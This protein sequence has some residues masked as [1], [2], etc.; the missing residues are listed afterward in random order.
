[1]REL[2]QGVCMHYN[3]SSLFG[4]PNLNYSRHVESILSLLYNIV[5]HNDYV[6]NSRK[7]ISCDPF[8]QNVKDK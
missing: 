7:F 8:W 4:N 2:E 6:C 1:M 5:K 3:I